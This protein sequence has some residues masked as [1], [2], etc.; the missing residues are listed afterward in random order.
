MNKEKSKD[1]FDFEEKVQ[2]IQLKIEKLK[3]LCLKKGIDYSKELNELEIKKNQ[4]LED[5]YSN[6]NAWQIVQVARHLNR[7]ILENYLGRMIQDFREMHGDGIYGDDKAIIT[8]L[9]RI[10]REKVMVVGHNKGR[11]LEG[12]IKCNFG[13]AMPE[14]YRKA[15]A[16]MR[17]AE[18]YEIPIVTFIDTPGA[19]PG[20]GAEE[21]GQAKAIAYN[22]RE[23]SRLKVPIVSI[24]IGEG[25][26]GGALGIGVGDKL[27]MLEYSYYSVI[28][29]EGC[30][31]I[32]WRDRKKAP[33]AAEALGLTSRGL[34]NLGLIDDIIKEPIGGA[35]RNYFL[36][37]DNVKRY[38]LKSLS[39]LKKISTQDLL[40]KRYERLRSIGN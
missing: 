40:K 7:P 14:G 27:A 18:K 28:S 4:K 30:A 21:R 35:H 15:L 11:G 3:T 6:L 31:G 16:K 8:G 34:H 9:G 23:M 10:G 5:I 26:S 12:R 13:C 1:Y 17:F 38:V 32:L 24:V 29:P 25:G 19:E 33:E 22:L 37:F 2:K 39:D 20:I 36:V